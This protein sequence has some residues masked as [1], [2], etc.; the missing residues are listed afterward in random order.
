MILD[1][2]VLYEIRAKGSSMPM[3]CYPADPLD[4]TRMFSNAEILGDGYEIRAHGKLIAEV[5][6]D[7]TIREASTE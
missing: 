1:R 2:L 6:P 3:Y 4:L 7:G 5:L